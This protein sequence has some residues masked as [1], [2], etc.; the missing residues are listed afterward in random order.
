[1]PVSAA[2]MD[3]IKTLYPWMTPTLLAVYTTSWEIHEDSPTA[4]AEV[5]QSDEYGT[6]FAGNYDPVS[7][8]VRMGESDYFASKANFEATLIGVGVN[9]AFFQDEWVEAL[10]GEVSPSE[11]TSRIESIFER[12]MD[13]AEGIRQY[14]AEIAGIEMTD[15]AMVASALKPGLEGQILN[16]QITMAEIGGEAAIRGFDISRAMARELFQAQLGRSEAVGLFGNA[17]EDLPALNILARRHADP[18]DTFDLEEFIT[19]DIYNDP[20][21]RQRMRRLVAQEKSSFGNIGA[22][23]EFARSG[24]GGITGLRAS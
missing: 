7:G 2:L 12:V 5:R 8:S 19:A 24:R 9:P 6:I 10:E 3:Q 17:R 21:Q 20:A 18:D 15:A 4:L 22:Q 14:Y 11:M 16:R 23:T 13:Q 1:M